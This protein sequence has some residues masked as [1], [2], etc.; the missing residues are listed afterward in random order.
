MRLNGDI[1]G[2]KR[3]IATFLSNL[4][5]ASNDIP[6]AD[7]ASLFLSQ[8]TNYAYDFA[9]AAA[10]QQ[11]Q[12]WMPVQDVHGKQEQLLWD[13][14]YCVGRTMRGEGRFLEAKTC[15]ETCLGYS[16][17]SFTK[18][19]LV[20]SSLADLYCELDYS[21]VSGRCYLHHAK[22]MVETN[23]QRLRM[24][25][26]QHLK[27]YRR[28]LL[29]AAE[30]YI[31]Q[32]HYHDAETAVKELLDIYYNLREMD[33][34]DRLGHVRSLIA[35]ARLSPTSKDALQRWRDVLAWNKFYNPLEEEVFTCCLVYYAL[36]NTL[37]TLGD[38]NGSVENYC[39]AKRVSQRKCRQFLIPG[40][41]TYIYD[42]VCAPVRSTFEAL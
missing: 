1:E 28:L 26:R 13:Q 19:F 7:L 34:V 40:V 39:K 31:R 10:H 17:L 33:I 25:S 20:N 42:A 32:H 41:G 36:S 12:N 22:L 4:N 24:S 37:Y 18:S 9:F 21:D 2:S 16:G 5:S 14:I 38:L 23:I 3:A 6:Y 15:F 11:I 29:S 8:A 35:F 30:V 27:G